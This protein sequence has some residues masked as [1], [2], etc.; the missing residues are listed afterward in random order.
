M[1]R[2]IIISC[3][4]AA[5]ALPGQAQ[6]YS[7]RIA[8][9]QQVKILL[10][11]GEMKIEGY[12]GNEVKITAHNYQEPPE[13]AKG[14][15]PLYNS[16]QDNTGI[17]LAVTEESGTLLIQEASGQEGAYT[18]RLPENIRLSIEQLNWQGQD[19]DVLN[20]KNEIEVKGKNADMH[21]KGVQ[22]PIFVNSTAGNINIV[23]SSLKQDAVSMISAVSSEVDITL[24]ASSKATFLLKSITGEIYTDLDLQLK[25]QEG[26]GNELRRVGGGQHIEGTTNGGGGAEL[27]INTISSNIYIRKAQ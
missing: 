9:N 5:W 18:L 26:N 2:L 25:K 7:K 6:E 19:I 4:L 24:P 11:K 10:N 20:M 16:A 8:G 23:Y 22:G 13:R 1:K 27:S 12:N 14:L 17:G 3:W 21:L 15:R